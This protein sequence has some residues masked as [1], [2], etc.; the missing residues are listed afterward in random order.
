[1]SKAKTVKKGQ[2]KGKKNDIYGDESEYQESDMSE[3]EE[4]YSLSS[5]LNEG[6]SSS[7][8]DIDEDDLVDEV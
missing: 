8:L 3:S 2:K 4:A 5:D 7:E 6:S 1:M